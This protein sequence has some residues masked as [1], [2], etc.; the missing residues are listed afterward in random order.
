[1]AYV[2]AQ[3][4]FREQRV[5]DLE[6]LGN[7]VGQDIRQY[8]QGFLLCH[9]PTWRSGCE[10]SMRQCGSHQITATSTMHWPALTTE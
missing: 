7:V 1:M 10:S 5:L 4:Q 2:H 9:A 6:V 3:A 8:F